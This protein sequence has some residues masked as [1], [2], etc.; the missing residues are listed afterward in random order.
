M[1]LNG[2]IQQWAGHPE[3]TEQIGLFRRIA[4]A[5]E[6]T[7]KCMGAVVL[8]SFAK[9]TADRVSDLDLVT[10]CAE[11][12]G[13]ALLQLIRDQIPAEAIFAEFHGAHGPDS[14]FC[15][16]ILYNFTSIEFHVIAPEAKFTIKNPF[17]EIINRNQCIEARMSDRTA[18]TRDDLVPFRHGS[19]WL[20]WELFNCMKWLSRGEVAAA[21]KY[22][23]GLGR[24]IESSKNDS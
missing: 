17:V 14:P 19:A 20:P 15:E 13:Q 23:V 4:T 9:N 18:P 3:T 22:L 10:F 24:A 2:F 21:E 6:N 7:E 8:G 5:L 16:L 12:Q 11:G 1:S